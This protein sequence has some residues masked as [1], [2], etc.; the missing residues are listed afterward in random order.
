MPAE[1]GPDTVTSLGGVPLLVDDWNLDAV[2][3]GSQKCL[4]CAPGL[5]PVTFSARA[6]EKVRG[7]KS[8]IQSWFLDLTLVTAYWGAQAKRVYHHTA[9]VNALYGLHESLVMLKE[10]GLENAW[11]RHK[12]NHLELLRGLEAMGLKLLVKPEE[13]L[14][15]LNAVLLPEGDDDATIRAKLL[16][17]YNIEIGAGLGPLAGKIWRIGLMGQSSNKRNIAFCLQAFK[18][19]LD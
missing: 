17:D 6:M 13:R 19:V 5:S 12:D 10:E 2:Y 1:P 15:Q 7:R 4:S 16:K 14:P 9:P 18:E 3:S 11:T 8:K